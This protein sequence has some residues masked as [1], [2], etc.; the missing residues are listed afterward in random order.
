MQRTLTAFDVGRV[1]HWPE[2]TCTKT[3]R[4][5][6]FAGAA[7]SRKFCSGTTTVVVV[8]V[9]CCCCCWHGS[10]VSEDALAFARS[11]RTVRQSPDRTGGT[12]S[13]TAITARAAVALA[14]APSPTR[15]GVYRLP[16]LPPLLPSLL[17]SLLLLL[18]LLPLLL[19]LLLLLLLPLLLLLLLL[20]SCTQ[21]SGPCHPSWTDT[22][23]SP[24]AAGGVVGKLG[25]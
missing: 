15:L 22:T 13:H 10:T 25:E 20:P 14:M 2:G 23:S 6:L 8:P 24:V 16:L 12:A 9:C 1:A 17:P 18:L 11:W 7:A 21:Q 19:L 4:P 5:L 3:E